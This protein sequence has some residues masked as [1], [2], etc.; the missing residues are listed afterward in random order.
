MQN[1]RTY[2]LLKQEIKIEKIDL[3][4]GIYVRFGKIASNAEYRI[5]EQFQNCT[6]FK[7]NFSKISNSKN[8]R[9]FQFLKF[10]KFPIFK[11]P[12]FAIWEIPKISN[13][14]ISKKF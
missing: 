9:N 2:E 6:F 7:S 8:S 10:L 3:Y 5:N 1:G 14:E 13:F 4:Q 12:D 11:N